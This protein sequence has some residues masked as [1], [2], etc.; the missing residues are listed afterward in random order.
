MAVQH[1]LDSLRVVDPA[2]LPASGATSE[3]VEIDRKT[4]TVRVSYCEPSV[5]CTSQSV[6]SLTARA[7]LNGKD[8]FTATTVFAQLR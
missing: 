5:L 4:Y 2:T 1:V 8:Y 3:Q 6:R 7:E